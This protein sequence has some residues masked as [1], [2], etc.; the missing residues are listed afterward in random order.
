MHVVDS[1]RLVNVLRRYQRA[2][3]VVAIVVIIA[4][5]AVYVARLVSDTQIVD[6]D[7]DGLAS[8]IYHPAEQKT[9]R[10][11]VVHGI[12]RHCIGYA[13][14]F[15]EKLTETLHLRPV[16][17]IA[18]SVISDLMGDCGAPISAAYDF[19]SSQQR[20][21]EILNRRHKHG[22]TCQRLTLEVEY[23]DPQTSEPAT[24]PFDSGFIRT[25]DYVL[26]KKRSDVRAILRVYELTWDVATRANKLAYLEAVDSQFA[27][28][29]ER[30]NN[31][32]K[33]AIINESVSDAVLYLGSYKRLMQYPLLAAFCKI[34]SPDTRPQNDVFKCDFE[35]LSQ[36]TNNNFVNQ[37]EIV[38]VTHSLGTR[39]LFDTLGLVTRQ[40][41]LK[42]VKEDLETLGV[43]FKYRE[44]HETVGKAMRTI[45]QGSVKKIF[46][47]A[48]QVPLL[49]LSLARNPVAGPVSSGQY[50]D[51]GSGF[52]AFLE[53]RQAQ[54]EDPLQ[55]VAF[56]DPNDMLSY[57]LK[58]WYYLNVL[59]FH[60][61]IRA[62]RNKDKTLD[63][64]WFRKCNQMGDEIMWAQ[65]ADVV[66]L[67]DVSLK[68]A[69]A[70][71]FIFANPAAAH[72]NYFED[73][74]VVK[75]IACGGSQETNGPKACQQEH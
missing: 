37:N 68:L 23:V 35:T 57:N 17:A 73:D 49:Q 39:M 50:P 63:R 44:P 40:H 22:T 41:F 25:Q 72:S 51:L 7:F 21:C 2:I 9:I 11:L 12:G 52:A 56:T 16:G 42:I 55:I 71:P 74:R 29:R 18:D 38:I 3:S 26:T 61:K 46:T 30:L 5:I 10:L 65:A 34:L 19:I 20:G 54:A 8:S 48:N 67:S 1:R 59:R 43:R 66:S 32:F 64:R 62:E 36:H 15:L 60:P 27:H 47:L 28:Q 75:M 24:S 53:Q 13:A 45:F 6:R 4:A 58:C 14:A 70:L 33:R 69:I 31:A